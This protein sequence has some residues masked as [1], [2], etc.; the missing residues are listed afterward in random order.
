MKEIGITPAKRDNHAIYPHP[1]P[2][3]PMHKHLLATALGLSLASLAHDETA[4][5]SWLHRTLPA[6]TAAYARIPDV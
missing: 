2:R 6:E 4:Q 1:N 5:E 3:N